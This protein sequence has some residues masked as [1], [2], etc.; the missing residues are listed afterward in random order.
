MKKTTDKIRQDFLKFFK[1]K[2]HMIIPSSSL[3][4]YNDSTLLFTNAGMNQ[5]KEIF[6]GEKKSNYP[7]V[8]TV[9]RCLRTGGKHNDLENVGYTSKHHTFFEMLGNF[10]FGDYFKKQAIEYAWE[11]LTSK[12][13]FNIPQNKLWISVYKDDTETYKIWNDIIKIPSE[14]I[15]RIGDKNKE[16]YNSENFWQMGDTGPCGP[17]TEIFYDYS[18]T[19]KIDPIEFLE[20]KNGRFVEIWNIVFIE[21]NRISK[22]KIISLKNKSIDTGM[23][24]ERISAVLQNV[25][26]NYHIDV[27]QKLIKNI[28]QLSSI[29]NLDH[30]SFQVIAD[31][32]RSCSYIIADNILPSNEHRG[33]ILRR[34]IRRALRHGHKIGI[35][36]NFFHKLVSSVIHV[37]GKTGDILKE[38]QEKIENVLKIEEMQ[39]SYTLEKGLKIL[40]SEIE[41]IDN[42]ILSG[43]TAF[44]LYDTFGFP[45]D[46]TSDVCREKNIK[47][48]YN[49]YELAKEKQKEQ[50]NIN[51]KF[52]KNYNNNIILNDTCIFEGY[53]KTITRSLVKYIF[54]NN[55][56]VSKIIKDEKG[57]IFLDKTPFYSES[58]GQIGDIGQLYH[59]KSSFLVEKTK[60]Y[61]KTIGH[62][63]KLIS[64]QITLNDSLFSHI[65]E[66]YRYAIQLNH[67]AT[68]LLHATLR[69]ILGDSIVQKGSLVTNTYLRFDFSYVKSIDTSQIQKIENII[70]T[71]IR[72]NIK[73]KTEELNLE[74]AKKKKAMALF[75]DQ[76]GSI[77][78]VVFIN[79]FSIELCGG[80]HTQRTGDIG[81]FKIISQ[82]SVASGIK[83]IEAVTGQ[84]AIDYLHEKDNYI[85]DISL[86]LNCSTVDIKEKTKKLTIKTKNLEK[87]IIQ[88]QKKENTQY[89]KKILKNVTEIKGTKLLTNIFYD[90][91]QKSLRMIVDQLKKELKNTIIILIN[92]INNRFTIIVGVTRN[93][94]DYIT[95]IK[96][97]EMIINKTN[98]K[99]GGKKEIAEGGGA[100][101]KQLPSI[102]NTIK[103]WI[104][105]KLNEK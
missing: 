3:V 85:K 63:G 81:L 27:F 39:F 53:T 1:E 99:G 44:Y 71:N 88:L 104:N 42:N 15:I 21:F 62:I 19:M 28:A 55:Q 95:A 89:I 92:I 10:S 75:D 82:S 23:G 34:I 86:L 74:E 35:K 38:K 43:K 70:N 25:Y 65:D 45:I 93:L 76:Y 18:D 11:L 26:S 5:F 72:N 90:Y 50:S 58:G 67:S 8:A 97:M 73:I 17:C 9:Q 2:G 68:H 79:N 69:K 98:G 20:N 30:I 96:I 54:V 83:R 66:D 24:L 87:K 61:G 49:S 12:K 22:T 51:K 13:W 16:K 64:G 48:D 103:L 47:I 78:R 46:L 6:L 14:R 56:S 84:K 91:E 40:N 59:K 52:Y 105:D 36:K 31:H 77:V 33:Y 4:P 60:K 37:M 100:N 57:V 94:L 29:N 41:K 32:I 101:T 102:L 80:T 7:R